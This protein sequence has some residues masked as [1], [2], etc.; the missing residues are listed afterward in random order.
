MNGMNPTA[1]ADTFARDRL[2]PPEQQPEFVFELPELQLP[3]RLNCAA[4][5]LDRR[6]AGGEGGRACIVAPGLRWTY[7][8]LQ[9]RADRIAHVLVR[10]M[11]LVPEIGRA[12]V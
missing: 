6:V 1:H 10:D 11:G 3:P 5:L 2:P 4:E 9:D 8:D 7:A 12:H